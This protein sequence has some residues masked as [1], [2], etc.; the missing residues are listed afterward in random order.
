MNRDGDI[1]L[2]WQSVDHWAARKPDAEALVFGDRRVTWAELAGMV[3]RMACGLI[4]AGVGRGDCVA[5]VSAACPEFIISF[6]GAS[7]AGAMWVGLS[8]VYP[9]E[10][11][12]R[13]LGDCR[14]AV[15]LVAAEHRG[16]PLAGRASTLMYE[17]PSILG[18]YVIGGA[19]A[20]LPAFEELLEPSAECAGL[21][22]E[23]AAAQ[24]PGDETL[25]IY[26]SG[27]SG[28][29]KGVIHTHA[30][31]LA[32]VSQEAPLFG[33]GG[34]DR[35]L[36]HFPINHVAAD[37]EIGLCSIYAGA[38]L[39]I[40][41]HFSPADV[42]DVIEREK[43]TVLGQVPAMYLMEYEYD[44][45][46]EERLQ[47]VKTY[48]YGGSI[49]T[50]PMLDVISG[51]CDRFGARMI[52]GYGATEFGGFITSTEP[53]AR[54]KSG[55]AGVA[56]PTCEVR[57]VDGGRNPLPA[58]E[59]GEIAVRGPVLMKGY[60]NKPALTNE[61]VD[62]D[63]WLYTRDLG[64]LDGKGGLE[65]LGRASDMYKSG[66]ENIFPAEVEAALQSHPGVMFAAVIGVPHPVYGE[67]GR[68]FVM[69]VPGETVGADDLK[70]HCRTRLAP[71]KVPES[72]VFVERMPLLP[73]GKVDMRALRGRQE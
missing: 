52:T 30:N 15:L 40:Q 1:S 22:A 56:Y 11:L 58:G 2:L 23:R 70:R 45:F 9:M 73:S 46:R 49:S 62:G 29:P 28:A 68:A 67:V 17:I 20:G 72:F 36:L 10:E 47:S 53:S 34:D 38:T 14:P 19:A 26:T 51:L 69:P 61:V 63:G 60:L 12:R 42:L 33:I 57:I 48:L 35:V 6:L 24:S 64:R 37:V 7:R 31:L 44:G 27:S 65:I 8:P 4:S 25:L 16:A 5:Q 55:E 50:Q 3:E 71:F 39:V 18:T 41:D 66:G 13:M 21:L 59:T 43:V 54:P 32:N